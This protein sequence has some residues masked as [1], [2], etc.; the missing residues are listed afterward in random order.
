MHFIDHSRR[1]RWNEVQEQAGVLNK[2]HQN[3]AEI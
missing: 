3:T 2:K 1:Q